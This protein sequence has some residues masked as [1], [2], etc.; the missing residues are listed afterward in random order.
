IL[1]N[2][3]DKIS[4]LCRYLCINSKPQLALLLVL[5]LASLVILPVIPT[6]QLQSS[7][8]SQV[9]NIYI[10]L[11]T[12]PSVYSYH[13]LQLHPLRRQRVHT[14]HQLRFRQVPSSSQILEAL[15]VKV[16]ALK[17]FLKI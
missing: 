3:D 6:H 14:I 10:Q 4:K 11:V 9:T 8:S 13:F 1:E 17:Y 5:E 15:Q 12:T 7:S 2:A 16:N